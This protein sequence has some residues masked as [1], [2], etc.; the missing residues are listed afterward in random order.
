MNQNKTH[1]K[2]RF[3]YDYLG[4]YSLPNEKNV[5]LTIS[6][7]VSK[8]VVGPTGSKEDCLTIEFSEKADW[9]K[10]MIL[11]RTN[12]KAIEKISGSGYIEDWTGVAVEIYIQKNVKAFG[13]TVDA[14]RIMPRKPVTT[15]PNLDINSDYVNQLVQY[16]KSGKATM[17]QCIIQAKKTYT[18]SKE[19]EVELLKLV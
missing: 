7:V 6:N 14:L 18:I 16:V 4:S 1:W 5:V 17:D 8:S 3:N 12:A 9:I 11:N 15:K 19:T 13:N 2:K 10:P